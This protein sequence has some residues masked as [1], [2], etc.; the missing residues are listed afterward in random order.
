MLLSVCALE[1]SLNI[2]GLHP[3]AIT[4]AAIAAELQSVARCEMTFPERKRMLP[5][6]CIC[7]CICRL[8]HRD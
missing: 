8:S 1:G 2:R 6:I 4:C 7:I 5:R 3:F